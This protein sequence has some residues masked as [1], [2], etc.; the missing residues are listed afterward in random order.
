MFIDTVELNI[1]SGK[2]GDGMIHFHREKYRP[3]GG[4]DG[5]DGGRGGSVF[6]EVQ[7]TLNTLTKF[8]YNQRFVAEDG[9]PGGPNNMSGKAASDVIIPVPPGTLVYDAVEDHL[10]GDLVEPGQSLLIAKGGRG[11]RG[12]Q[13]FATSRNQ[14]PRTGEKGEPGESISIRLELK[15]IADVG[16]VGVPNAGKSSL[17]AAVSNATPKIANYPFTTLEPNLGVVRLDVNQAMVLADIPGLI[18]GAHMG[19]GLGF[20]FLRHI[21][22]TKVIV[23]LLDGLSEDPISDYSQIN[24]EMA[25][26]DDKLA[27]KPQIVVFNKMDLPM[28]QERFEEVSQFLTKSGV[29]LMPIS[30]VAQLN[31]KELMWKA[32]H[33]VSMTA[34]PEVKQEIPLYEVENDPR[35]YKIERWGDGWHVSGKAIERAAAMTYWEHYGSVRRFQRV[36]KAIGIEADLKKAGIAEGDSVFIN[37]NVLEWQD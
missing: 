35:E 32:Y 16:L 12:N 36:M 10:L 24:S 1:Q 2:G 5:G 11:G 3:R 26:F 29:E 23:H 34:D 13:H 20:E 31:L 9:K 30:A 22:R 6:L 15:L 33:L 8:H 21:Q 17:L 37:D 25:L 4:P 27:E 19:V 7:P 18:E 28:A 14:A